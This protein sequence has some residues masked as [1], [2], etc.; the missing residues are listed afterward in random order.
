MNM[1][2]HL[3]VFISEDAHYS[4]HKMAALLGIGERNVISVKTDEY[5][6]MDTTHLL[7]LIE[8]Y[9]KRPNYYPFMVIGTAG[10]SL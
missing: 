5:G 7:Q 3:I 2:V 8:N 1:A 6:R 9:S 10:M 4:I